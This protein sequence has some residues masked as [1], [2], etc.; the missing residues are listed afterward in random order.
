MGWAILG[1]YRVR[2]CAALG[3]VEEVLP[4]GDRLAENESERSQQELKAGC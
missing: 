1:K 2:T 3:V 4:P